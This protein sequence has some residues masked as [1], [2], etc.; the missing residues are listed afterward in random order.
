M[1]NNLT[2][3]KIAMFSNFKMYVP[4]KAFN[5]C[6]YYGKTQDIFEKI[7]EPSTNDDWVFWIKGIP[8]EMKCFAGTKDYAVIIKFKEKEKNIHLLFGLTLYATTKAVDFLLEPPERFIALVSELDKYCIVVP[9]E[10]K[11]DTGMDFT[12]GKKGMIFDDFTCAFFAGH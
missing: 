12:Y 6:N 7:V 11:G 3:N 10:K 9:L 2:A 4:H 5:E 1:A 8:K